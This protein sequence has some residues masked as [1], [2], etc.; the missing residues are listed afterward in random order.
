MHVLQNLGEPV[1]EDELEDMMKDA[2]KNGDGRID[3]AEFVAVL[4]SAQ[5]LPPPVVIS[6]ELKPYWE[7]L[8]NK[9]GHKKHAHGGAEEPPPVS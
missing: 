9:E 3:Y 6:E 5:D 1:E 4:F 7:A 8:K 2:D